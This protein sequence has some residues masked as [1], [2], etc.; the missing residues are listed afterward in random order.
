MVPLHPLASGPAGR[1][2]VTY[3]DAMKC[4]KAVAKRPHKP[5]SLQ[6]N[7]RWPYLAEGVSPDDFA[8]RFEPTQFLDCAAMADD[9]NPRANPRLAGVAKARE[10]PVTGG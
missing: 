4:G 8:Q 5:L 1:Y 3:T 10:K 2:G 6:N 7:P 9:G